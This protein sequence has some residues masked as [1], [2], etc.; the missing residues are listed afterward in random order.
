MF[1]SCVADINSDSL[2][3]V[4]D[5]LDLL[6]AWGKNPRHPADID[7]DRMVDEA[8]RVFCLVRGEPRAIVLKKGDRYPEI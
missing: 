5:F 4:V 6:N 2:V 7:N 8:D 1:D 3:N